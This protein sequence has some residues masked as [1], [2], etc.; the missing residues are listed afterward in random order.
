M[1]ILLLEG[2]QET[3]VGGKG[4]VAS[5]KRTINSMNNKQCKCEQDERQGFQHLEYTGDCPIQI[6]NEN[7]K[8]MFAIVTQDSY[9][10]T[11]QLF[12]TKAQA[13]AFFKEIDCKSI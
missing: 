8:F 12:K 5:Y 1:G 11:I 13:E 3:A 7:P 2:R 10:Q 9:G 4:G 6:K